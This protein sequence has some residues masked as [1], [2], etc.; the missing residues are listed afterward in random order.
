MTLKKLI[1]S[2]LLFKINIIS[3]Q[4]DTLDRCN[5]KR[6]KIG[7]WKVYLDSNAR[8]TVKSNAVYYVYDFYDNGKRVIRYPKISKG[9]DLKILAN[10][11]SKIGLPI[12]L[13]GLINGY[14][15]TDIGKQ[16]ISQYIYQNGLPVKLIGCLYLASLKKRKNIDKVCLF[17]RVDYTK[18]YKGQFGTYY[19]ES[20]SPPDTLNCK[21]YWYRKDKRRW[22]FHRIDE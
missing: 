20:F 1:L 2:I 16:V 21:K 14:Y 17:E 4:S 10:Q 19:Y 15:Y 22:K 8:R 5:D 7:F 12:L 18:K 13:T 6:E 3:A 9:E 11:T